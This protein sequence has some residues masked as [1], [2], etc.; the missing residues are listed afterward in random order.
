[1]VIRLA[2]V[3]ATASAMVMVGAA[4]AAAHVRAV[5]A[6]NMSSE[7]RSVP[8]VEGVTWHVYA[9]GQL[10]SLR[11]DGPS[12]IVVHG[13]EGEPYLRIGPAGVQENRNSPATYLNSDRYGDVALPPRADPEAPPVWRA[14]TSR[15][16]Y[17]WHDHRTHWMSPELP[18]AVREAPGDEQHILDWV[19]PLTIDGAKAELRGELSWVPHAGRTWWWASLAGAMLLALV[20]G[21]RLHRPVRI[22]AGIVGS[23]AGANAIHLIDEIVA[24]PQHWLD[25]L[26]GFLHT[27]LF[28]LLG[29]AAAVWVLR[30][31]DGPRLA[32]GIG[33]GGIAFH[34]GVLQFGLLGAMSVDTVWP[35]ALLRVLV[36]A[37]LA[38]ATFAIAA[39]A[40]RPVWDPERPP[41][42]G[43]FG[44]RDRGRVPVGAG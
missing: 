19:V 12:T 6:S 39:I 34:Q 2:L 36:I 21:L 28:V 22:A 16:E 7:I 8:E 42:D 30:G 9:G 27:G 14:V 25:I 44:P 32:L 5:E 15:S 17:V 33:A 23:I 43:S 20:A 35:V 11:S 29:I 13:Y 10:V 1:M 18:A 40:R 31:Q 3:L 38:S 4:P 26:G 41:V 37:S 24:R